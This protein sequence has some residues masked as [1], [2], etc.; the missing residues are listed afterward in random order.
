LKEAFLDE[1]DITVDAL[2]KAISVPRS[3]INGIVLGRPS[4]T[5]DTALRLG[6]FLTKVSRF[7]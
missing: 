7:F 6:H 5:A 1:M 2:L 3:R 4:I